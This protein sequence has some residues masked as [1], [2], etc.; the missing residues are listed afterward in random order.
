MKL[1]RRKFLHLA[2]G[3]TAL[4]FAPSIARAQA[5]PSRP[6]RILVGIAAGS[7]TDIY[8]RLIGQWLSERIGQPY[9]IENLPGAGS[10]LATA[11]VANAPPDGYTLLMIASA[12]V[13]AATLYDTLTFNFVRDIAPVAGI[14]SVPLVIVVNPSFQAKTVP[15]FI[16]YAKAN[17]GKL[18][19][20]SG[21][22]GTTNHLAGELFKLMTGVDM[23]HVPNR[24]GGLTDLISG[25]A[26]VFF[27]AVT[28][29]IDHIRADKLRALAVTSATRVEALPDVP[30]VADFV[31]GYEAIA[32]N[33][34][35][36]PK[37]TP[38]Q[39]IDKLN[40]EIN[41]ALTD[42][43]IKARFAD[44][45]GVPMP[46]TPGEFGNFITDETANWAKVI[47]AANL[48]PE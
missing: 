18:N 2:A 34:V 23:V 5:Y 37:N 21:G 20:A 6:V 11:A 41:A 10:N 47:K 39:I 28:G 12:N 45:G 44:L 35:G 24:S 9:V 27:A 25:Q 7:P 3:A 42:P 15:E 1:P 22:V 13:I 4:P 17:R 43:K 31:P 40:K 26:H 16:A 33:G 29:A 38:S 46:M 19:M 14:N 48:R 8:A 30:T 32:W 36:A